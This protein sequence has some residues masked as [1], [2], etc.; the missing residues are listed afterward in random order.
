MV[1]G[2]ACLPLCSIAI[3]EEEG[4]GVHVLC[5]V[6]LPNEENTSQREAPLPG[7][8][9]AVQVHPGVLGGGRSQVCSLLRP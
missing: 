5:S 6:T 7:L 4:P 8:A 9:C 2:P 3:D 1:P